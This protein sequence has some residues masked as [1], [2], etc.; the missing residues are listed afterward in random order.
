MAMEKSS[1]IHL[2]EEEKKIIK[3]SALE[4]KASEE[5]P[6]PERFKGWYTNKELQEFL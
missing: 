4:K 5:D 2:S 3:P 6:V 1:E